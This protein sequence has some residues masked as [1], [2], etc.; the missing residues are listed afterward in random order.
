MRFACAASDALIADRSRSGTSS[1]SR[2]T[3]S[4]PETTSQYVSTVDLDVRPTLRRGGAPRGAGRGRQAVG[5]AAAHGA[6]LQR[7]ARPSVQ[8]RPRAV[9]APHAREESPPVRFGSRPGEMGYCLVVTVRTETE[10]PE[11]P[12]GGR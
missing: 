12:A 11:P 7:D 1:S 6:V 8:E 4:A 2:P 10:P 3:W 5:G 9:A